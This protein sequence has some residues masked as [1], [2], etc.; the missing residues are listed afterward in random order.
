MAFVLT[1]KNTFVTMCCEANLLPRRRSS[2]DFSITYSEEYHAMMMDR[3]AVWAKMDDAA[4]VSTACGDDSDK[5]SVCSSDSVFNQR[6]SSGQLAEASVRLPAD[7]VEESSASGRKRKGTQLRLATHLASLERQDHRCILI[8][9]KINRLGFGAADAL[10][11]HYCLYGAVAEV[12]LSTTQERDCQATRQRLRPS[13]MGWLRFESAS[14]AA[15]ALSAGEEQIVEGSHIVVR[16]FASRAAM[17]APG[18]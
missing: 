18:V 2:S 15:A 1:V 8:L 7:T 6:P 5:A 11:R 16:A 13:S 12:L 9:K 10:K 17:C 3:T 14:A 4:S